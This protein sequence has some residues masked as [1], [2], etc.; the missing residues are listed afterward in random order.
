MTTKEITYPNVG[1]TPKLNPAQN[2]KN[3]PSYK[4]KDVM[5][6]QSITLSIVKQ[7]IKTMRS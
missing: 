1:V 3:K 4:Y 5:I 7:M 6:R 2:G